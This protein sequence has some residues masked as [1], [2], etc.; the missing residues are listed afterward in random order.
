MFS[1]DPRLRLRISFGCHQLEFLVARRTISIA[2]RAPF[3]QQRGIRR[4]DEPLPRNGV[5]DVLRM[6][7]TLSPPTPTKWTLPSGREISI[8]RLDIKPDAHRPLLAPP[9]SLVLETSQDPHLVFDARLFAV[10]KPGATIT[11]VAKV[12]RETGQLPVILDAVLEGGV[13][14]QRSTVQQ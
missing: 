10:C 11:C 6:F 5:H 2:E 13:N 12:P 3:A 14:D 9:E 1:W 7:E 4:F 8:T